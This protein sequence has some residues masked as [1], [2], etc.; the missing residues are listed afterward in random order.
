[1]GDYLYCATHK[2]SLLSE[3]VA[4]HREPD[5]K[6]VEQR[7]NISNKVKYNTEWIGKNI[8]RKYGMNIYRPPLNDKVIIP[9]TLPENAITISTEVPCTQLD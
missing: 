8:I 1:M 2:K 6:F 7:F 4:N 9:R 3:E 5:C